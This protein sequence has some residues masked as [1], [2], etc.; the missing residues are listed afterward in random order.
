M[1]LGT[2]SR[3]TT[4]NRYPLGFRLR[5]ATLW[6]NEEWYNDSLRNGDDDKV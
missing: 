5:I 1:Y 3:H 2:N 4:L 6:M